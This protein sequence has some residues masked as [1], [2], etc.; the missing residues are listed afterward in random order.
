MNTNTNNILRGESEFMRKNNK[1]LNETKAPLE[2]PTFSG[3][4]TAPTAG[5]N[6]NSAQVAT[7]AFVKNN[8]DNFLQVSSNKPINGAKLWFKVL[9]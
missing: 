1:I 2:S 3:V 6:T 4:P 7:T 5:N 8:L 9:S